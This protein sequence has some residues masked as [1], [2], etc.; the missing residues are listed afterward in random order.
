M[1]GGG[2]TPPRE[3]SRVQGI[4][5]LRRQK[6]NSSLVGRKVAQRPQSMN[7]STPPPLHIV[8]ELQL[9]RSVLISH[10]LTGM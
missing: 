7:A 6:S 2:S 1:D 3:G 9:P 10:D 8:G 5:T 4:T